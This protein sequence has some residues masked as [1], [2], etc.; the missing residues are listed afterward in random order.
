M[1]GIEVWLLVGTGLL[2]VELFL[3]CRV[4][5]QCWALGK[6][7]RRAQR[8]LG[9]RGGNEARKECVITALWLQTIKRTSSLALTIVTVFLPLTLLYLADHRWKMHVFSMLNYGLGHLALIIAAMLY[10][11]LRRRYGG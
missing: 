7:M 9:R 10:A 4:L 11:L 8:A 3:R 5:K 6:I 2:T 1:I